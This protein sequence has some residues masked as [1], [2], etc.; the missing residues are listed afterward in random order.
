MAGGAGGGETYSG[1]G[2]TVG[3]V[4]IC[5]VAGVA[6]G[7]GGCVVVVGVALHAGKRCMCSSQRIVGIE[8]VIEG[9]RSPIRGV[10][11]SVA[12]GGKASCSVVRVV[13]PVEIRL[14]APDAGSR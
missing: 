6:V 10:V 14:M 2:R 4:V 3:P 5:L 9:Y 12:G 1:V 7:G 11:A 8:S 13:C